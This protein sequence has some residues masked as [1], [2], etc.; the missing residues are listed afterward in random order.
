MCEICCQKSD[1]LRLIDSNEQGCDMAFLRESCRHNHTSPLRRREIISTLIANENPQVWVQAHQLAGSATLEPLL[2]ET[3][4]TKKDNLERKV[5]RIWGLCRKKSAQNHFPSEPLHP[6]TLTPIYYLKEQLN[7]CSYKSVFLCPTALAAIIYNISL[8]KVS[9]EI[10]E[11]CYSSIE[12]QLFSMTT[13]AS[14]IYLE[15]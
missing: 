3:Q 9:K 11:S 13:S 6:H 12:N 5:T 15:N 14:L 10:D 4:Q 2:E 7:R 1:T 8:I